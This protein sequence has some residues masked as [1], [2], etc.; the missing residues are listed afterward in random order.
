MYVSIFFYLYIMISLSIKKKLFIHVFI[1]FGEHEFVR[2]KFIDVGNRF[3][4][5]QRIT[6]IVR[7]GYSG[8]KNTGSDKWRNS[9][10]GVEKKK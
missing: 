10:R 9:N 8:E 3:L 5:L 7:I 4:H 2:Q 6:R 1:W